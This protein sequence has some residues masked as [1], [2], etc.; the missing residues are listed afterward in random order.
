[1]LKTRRVLTLAFLL[2]LAVGVPFALAPRARTRLPHAGVPLGIV[3]PGAP[4][5]AP[6]RPALSAPPAP[7]QP[8]PPTRMR[9]VVFLHGTGERPDDGCEGLRAPVRELGWL[10]C[11]R[12]NLAAGRGYTW[13]GGAQQM[14]AQIAA[15][16]ARLDGT[17]Q[18]AIEWSRPGVL[19]AFSQGAYVALE[20]LA[21][22]PR[23]TSAAL[24]IGAS[25]QP[26][27]LTLTR[28]GVSRVGFA[29]GRYDMTY[30]AMKRSAEALA[31][32]G[33]EARFFDLGA[34][35]HTY[36]AEDPETLTH[37]LRWLGATPPS[38]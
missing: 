36:A 18:D 21:A 27:K 31:E 20:V 2:G 24:F 35:G 33:V 26:S 37:I 10:V 38:A 14:A 8:P 16:E 22:R 17:Q 15:A 28:L 13:G 3:T 4:N 5:E 32:Q 11:P 34:V 6:L 23:R 19:I 12:G 25:I 30:A 9:E 29:A 1:M 7:P